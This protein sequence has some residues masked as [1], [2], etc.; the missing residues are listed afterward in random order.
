MSTF[1][2]HANLAGRLLAWERRRAAK[3]ASEAG[4]AT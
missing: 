1:G 3:K 2:D 4:E